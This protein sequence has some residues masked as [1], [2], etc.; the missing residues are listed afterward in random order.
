MI[1]GFDLST[2]VCGYTILDGEDIIHINHYKF[3]SD[4]L[5]ERATELE[6]LL[7]TI[8]ND[9]TID[10]FCIEERLKSFRAGGTNA[11]AML[12]TA[13]LNFLCQ[14]LI[15]KRG[16]TVTEIN[17]NTARGKVFS[18]FHKIARTIKGIK[19]KEIAFEFTLKKLGD[20][21]FPKKIVKSG[22]NKGAE[23]YID[24][25]R[26]R[27]DSYIIAQAGYLLS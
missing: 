25:A 27:A 2:T 4:T 26:D 23:V 15:T 9:Y 12:K 17:V 7:N 8:F 18:G 16:I 20:K 5:L 13:Q 3:T 19:Q 21:H 10:K 22:K 6:T 1:L 11:E 24:E 14:Y